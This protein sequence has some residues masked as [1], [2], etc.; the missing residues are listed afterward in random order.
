MKM[1]KFFHRMTQQH[2]TD[3]KKDNMSQGC[4]EE[5]SVS[6]METGYANTAAPGLMSSVCP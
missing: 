6:W 3:R 5:D 2:S 4:A 1:I